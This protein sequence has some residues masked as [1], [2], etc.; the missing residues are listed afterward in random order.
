V[1]STVSTIAAAFAAIAV[2][3][4]GAYAW[5]QP[6][7]NSLSA[8]PIPTRSVANTPEPVVPPPSPVP[9]PSA[10]ESTPADTGEAAGDGAQLATVTTYDGYELVTGQGS[11]F[12]A[13]TAPLWFYTVEVHPD[14]RGELP[15]LVQISD[16]ALGDPN[17]GWTARGERALQR[18]DDLNQAAIRIVLAPAYVVD[19]ECARAGLDTVGYYSCWNGQQT[20]LNADRWAGATPDFADLNVYRHY[21]VNHEFGHGLGYNH[22]YC[23]APGAP[24]PVMAQQSMGLGAC[25]AN[26]WPYPTPVA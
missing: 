16:S 21:L 26:G 6:Q 8:Q 22:E 9:T 18:T 7:G 17:Q 11:R 2:L 4:F 13:E 10:V 25:V 20:M 23:Q 19:Q 24:A 3:V 15:S 1:R 14:L 12:G 5:G